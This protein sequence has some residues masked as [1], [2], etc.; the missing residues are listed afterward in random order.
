MAVNRWPR[1][2]YFADVGKSK[3]RSNQQLY[4]CFG[5]EQFLHRYDP[6]TKT[7]LSILPLPGSHLPSSCL[8]HSLKVTDG[9]LI[10][11]CL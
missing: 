9:A 5:E 1:K 8:S 11:H 7:P 10:I 2:Y 4:T 3:S 6:S